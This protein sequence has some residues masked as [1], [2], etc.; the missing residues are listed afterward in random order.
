[1]PWRRLLKAEAGFK[2]QLSSFDL[3]GGGSVIVTGLPGGSNGSFSLTDPSGHTMALKSI[4]N[5]VPGIFS[6]EV[7]VAG[8]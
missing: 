6:G 2:S 4:Q 1:V 5:R 3:G 8:V 7:K